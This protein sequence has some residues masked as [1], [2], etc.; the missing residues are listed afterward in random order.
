MI[1]VGAGGGGGSSHDISLP[2]KPQMLQIKPGLGTGGF[3][4]SMK[5]KGLQ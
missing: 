5:A 3:T 1:G 2:W 4:N